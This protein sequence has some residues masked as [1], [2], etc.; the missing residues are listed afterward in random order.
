MEVFMTEN[1][2]EV[3]KDVKVWSGLSGQGNNTSILLCNGGPG[4]ADYLDP[5]ANMIDDLY[6]V[7]RFEQRACGRSTVNYQCDLQTIIQDIEQIRVFYDIDSWVV[8]GHSWGANLSLAYALY[9]PNKV[10]AVLYIAGNGIQ[11]D[12]LWSEEYRKNRDTKGETIPDVNFNK[13]VNDITVD[14]WR[15]FIQEPTLLYRLSKLEIPILY[16]YGRNDIRPSW[17]VEQISNLTPNKKFEYIDN[18][19]HY[20]WFSHYHEMKN[21]LRDYLSGI[22]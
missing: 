13:Q 1:Y 16:V 6:K 2:V 14:S 21:I 19:E 10:K 8:G 20:I 3:S 7:I 11:N 22:K 17:P 18:A 12:R 9:F 15:R 4:M 5:V